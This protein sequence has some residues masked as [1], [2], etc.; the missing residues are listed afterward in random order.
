MKQTNWHT[1]HVNRV[2][3]W[4]A[5]IFHCLSIWSKYFRLIFDAFFSSRHKCVGGHVWF[6]SDKTMNSLSL[7]HEIFC[8]VGLLFLKNAILK[9]YVLKIYMSNLSKRKTQRPWDHFRIILSFVPFMK[10]QWYQNN[11]WRA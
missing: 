7:C 6:G 10:L 4:N 1:L 3:N 9:K 2:E 8:I 5:I 11:I